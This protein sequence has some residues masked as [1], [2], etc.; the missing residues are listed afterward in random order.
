MS[1]RAHPH[2]GLQTVSW[3]FSGTIQH[4]DSVG[5]VAAV[6][7]GELNLM[8]AGCGI[9]HSETSEPGD[10]PLLG[11]QLWLALP[12][13]HRWTAPAFEHYAPPEIEGDGMGARVFL[14]SLFGSTSPVTTFSSVVG[15]ELLLQAG[16]TLE[17][18]VAVDH[19]HGILLDFGSLRVDSTLLGVGELG[20][21]GPGSSVM[22][23]HAVTD[24]RVLLIGGEPLGE[25]IVM[26]WNFVGRSHEE[27]AEF[28]RQWNA[29]NARDA[30]GANG[31]RVFGWPKGEAQEPILAPGLPPVRLVPRA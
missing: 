4:R 9:S 5:T 10:G 11:V 30:I 29:E 2:T 13:A 22:V 7:P 31:R 1:V 8:T 15:A 24:S 12:D 17:I 27:I 20:C 16:T 23:L 6:R 25:P 21:L 28:Q 26:W 14:G 19:E 18:P 3:L